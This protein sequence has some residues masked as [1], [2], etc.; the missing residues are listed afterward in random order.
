MDERSRESCAESR[1]DED[2][3]HGSDSCV[4]RGTTLESPL[5]LV[6]GLPAYQSGREKD[7]EPDRSMVQRS[8]STSQVESSGVEERA[9]YVPRENKRIIRLSGRPGN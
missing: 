8:H 3:A 1:C 6:A 5:A 2:D 9:S 7:T 4:T